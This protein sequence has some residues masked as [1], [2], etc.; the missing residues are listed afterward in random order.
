MQ[1]VGLTHRPSRDV[2]LCVV[3]TSFLASIDPSLG[4][5]AARLSWWGAIQKPKKAPLSARG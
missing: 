5:L 1:Y 2:V 4:G 3:V